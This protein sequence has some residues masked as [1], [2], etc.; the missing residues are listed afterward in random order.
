[1]ATH[2][3]NVTIGT[4]TETARLSVSGQ[5]NQQTLYLDD[6]S[7]GNMVIKHQSGQILDF[8]NGC[9]LYTSPSPRDRG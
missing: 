1:M 9:L 3:G 4:D 7:Y 8:C 5:V 2:A 6:G